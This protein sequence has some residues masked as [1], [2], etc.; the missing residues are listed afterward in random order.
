[1]LPIPSSILDLHDLNAPDR[2]FCAKPLRLGPMQFTPFMFCCC[3]SVFKIMNVS[4]ADHV[5]P[6]KAEQQRLARDSDVRKCNSDVT[7]V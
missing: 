3:W 4:A 2:N 7:V 1:M 5:P 6:H